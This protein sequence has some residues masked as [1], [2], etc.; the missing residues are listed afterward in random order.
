L[1]KQG[2]RD[3]FFAPAPS[4]TTKVGACGCRQFATI[5]ILSATA[6]FQF[7]FLPEPARVR[8]G[9]EPRAPPDK[10]FGEFSAFGGEAKRK[11]A[12]FTLS[13]WQRFFL[14]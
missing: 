4:L 8:A 10:I 5:P 7:K 12:F 3:Q 11:A 13:F 6:N 9:K 2:G 14:I 1:H